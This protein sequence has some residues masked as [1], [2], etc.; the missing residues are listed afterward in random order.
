MRGMRCRLAVESSGAV[1][2]TLLSCPPSSWERQGAF[3]PR[4]AARLTAAQPCFAKGEALGPAGGPQPHEVT[5]VETTMP[6]G[7]PA[8]RD[9][10]GHVPPQ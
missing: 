2:R 6:A 5:M 9:H 7:G 8:T 1:F 3:C 10:A 4:E